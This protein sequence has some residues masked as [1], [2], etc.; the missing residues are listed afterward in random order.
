MTAHSIP[1]PPLRP[2]I[3]NLSQMDKENPVQSLMQLSRE[4]GPFFKFRILD[5]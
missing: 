4:Y 1:Q 2:V 5:R 3:G